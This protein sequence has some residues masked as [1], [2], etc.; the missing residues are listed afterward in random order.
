MSNV[1][2]KFP[3]CTNPG[4]R[5]SG[6]CKNCQKWVRA[7]P[8]RDWASRVFQPKLGPGECSI[9]GCRA[10]GVRKR[11]NTALHLGPMCVACYQ[12]AAAH[13][14]EDPATRA[15]PRAK[16]TAREELEA[17]AIATTRNCIVFQQTNGRG[18]VVLDGKPMSASRAVWAIAHGD[19]GE[20]HVLHTC[21]GG[22]GAHGRIN[23]RHLYADT[24]AR[25]MMDKVIA[26]HHRGW[27][28]PS[29]GE[30]HPSAKLVASQVLEIRAL[31]GTMSQEAIAER[32]GVRQITISRV[33]RRKTWTDI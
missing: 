11:L 26:G 2:C 13:P 28:S 14:G 4:H 23:I 7:N 17:A 30:K 32:F 31:A 20:L 21:N 15:R 25:N 18:K 1:T 12:W 5:G 9:S 22:S 8:D 29:R 27:S 19:P 6:L 10:V 33:V 3:G 24:H 16:G